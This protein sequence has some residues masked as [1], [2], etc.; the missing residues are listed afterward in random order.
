MNPLLP[1]LA[2]ALFIIMF[3]IWHQVKASIE[4]DTERKLRSL[5]Q[6]HLEQ[7]RTK[8]KRLELQH[9]TA[10]K[11]WQRIGIEVASRSH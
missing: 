9:E 11:K 4:L 1:I 8:F 10:I 6:D 7:F 5:D 3:S 2:M